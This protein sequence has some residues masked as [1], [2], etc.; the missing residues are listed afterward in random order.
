MLPSTITVGASTLEGYSTSVDSAKRD[1]GK[2]EEGIF[3]VGDFIAEKVE[4]VD[5]LVNP[6]PTSN[7]DLNL[8]P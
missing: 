5:S 2:A 3:Q 4:K 6:Q 7:K 8:L 1:F